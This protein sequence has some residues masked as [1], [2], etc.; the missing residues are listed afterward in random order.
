LHTVWIFLIIARSGYISAVMSLTCTY[1]TLTAEDLLLIK[2]V[3]EPQFIHNVNGDGQNC[4]NHKK[5]ILPTIT[6]S[7]SM[8]LHLLFY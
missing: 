7:K 2:K 5:V 4:K 3:Q 8:W 6:S 1:S